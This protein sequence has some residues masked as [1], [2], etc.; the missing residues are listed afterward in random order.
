M[1]REKCWVTDLVK[2]FLF[3]D[4]HKQKYARLGVQS[5]AGYE[6]D[7]F[8]ELGEK[9]I[10]WIERE[11]KLSMPKLVITLGAEVAGVITKTR[12]DVARNKLLGGE[13]KR[14]RIGQA[15]V[16][17]AH[18]PHPGIVMREAKDGVDSTNPWPALNKQFITK[19]VEWL[20]NQRS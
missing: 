20:K 5:P 6:R 11:L 8:E 17:A 19:L 13:V 12:G 15:E 10:P 2:V 1:A 14:I 4:G 18:L 3:K 16:D 7:S 9:S